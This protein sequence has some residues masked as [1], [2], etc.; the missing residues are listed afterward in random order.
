MSN[1]INLDNARPNLT[2]SE[3][4]KAFYVANSKLPL[5]SSHIRLLDCL[6]PFQKED[7]T[8]TAHPSRK[9]LASK[10]NRSICTI[11]RLLKQMYRRGWLLTF[12]SYHEQDGKKDQTTNNYTLAP[13]ILSYGTSSYEQSKK[14]VLEFQKQNI[15]PSVAMQLKGI[16]R[17]KA[18]TI[19]PGFD[20]VGSTRKATKPNL[21]TTFKENTIHLTVL[22]YEDQTISNITPDKPNNTNSYIPSIQKKEFNRGFNRS[23]NVELVEELITLFTRFEKHNHRTLSNLEKHRFAGAVNAKISRGEGTKEHYMGIFEISMSQIEESPLLQWSEETSLG[24]LYY[25]KDLMGH[26]KG[27]KKELDSL[28]SQVDFNQDAVDLIVAQ[29][30][31]DKN[32]NPEEIVRSLCGEESVTK[33]FLVDDGLADGTVGLEEEEALRYGDVNQSFDNEPFRPYMLEHEEYIPSQEEIDEFYNMVEPEQKFENIPNKVAHE[34]PTKFILSEVVS[35]ISVK[36]M[37]VTPRGKTPQELAV[38]G[39]VAHLTRLGV[40][41]YESK[42]RSLL[43]ASSLEYVMRLYDNPNQ[44]ILELSKQ[45]KKSA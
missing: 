28:I 31:V 10:I 41:S 11:D 25:A 36:P 30:A 15:R 37:V 21:L 18:F 45:L 38:D 42:L 8:S 40:R 22:T 3:C 20:F 32:A 13:T 12:D 4:H 35:Q 19:S 1:I 44:I 9:W 16:S 6:V 2:K 43:E 39:V 33:L 7:G 26:V 14:D 5:S 17:E 34:S 23:K 27:T 24:R 29:Y